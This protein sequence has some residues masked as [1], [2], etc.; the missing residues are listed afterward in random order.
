M[1]IIKDILIKYRGNFWQRLC[2]LQRT[3]PTLAA[4]AA[5]K[6]SRPENNAEWLNWNWTRLR[7]NS[8]PAQAYF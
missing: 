7:A 3:N 6:I 1:S 2:L 4:V 8:Q 5:H